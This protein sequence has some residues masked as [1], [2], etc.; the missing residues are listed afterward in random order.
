[1]RNVG[2]LSSFGNVALENTMP[3]CKGYQIGIA[4]RYCIR[5]SALCEAFTNSTHG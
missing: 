4:E 1:M 2:K 5:Q 3:R